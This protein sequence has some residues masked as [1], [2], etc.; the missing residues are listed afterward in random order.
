MVLDNGEEFPTVKPNMK[1][2]LPLQV[3]IDSKLEKQIKA[4][5]AVSRRSVT[6]EVNFLLTQGLR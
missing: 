1:R 3:R 6:K 2:K 4:R 5:A